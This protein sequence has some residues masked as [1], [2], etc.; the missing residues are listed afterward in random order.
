MS[1]ACRYLRVSAG[2]WHEDRGGADDGAD[3]MMITAV[4]VAGRSGLGGRRGVA[5]GPAHTSLAADHGIE[6]YENSVERIFPR[7]GECGTTEEIVEL[8]ARLASSGHD[9]PCVRASGSPSASFS[10]L[11]GGPER[12]SLRRW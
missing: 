7:L 1:S 12:G 11:V 3:P 5:G 4:T 9:R 10:L 8:L 6:V 2:A